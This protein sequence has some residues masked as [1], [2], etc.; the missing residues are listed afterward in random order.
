MCEKLLPSRRNSLGR[1]CARVWVS[2]PTAHPIA[3]PCVRAMRVRVGLSP[4]PEHVLLRR[5]V[6][7]FHPLWTLDAKSPDSNEIGHNILQAFDAE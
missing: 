7:E 2:D 4:S 6:V 1:R 5:K 3:T